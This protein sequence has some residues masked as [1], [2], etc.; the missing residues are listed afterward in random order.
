MVLDLYLFSVSLNGWS[1]CSARWSFNCWIRRFIY[2]AR[3][4]WSRGGAIDSSLCSENWAGLLLCRSSFTKSC[5][6]AVY[7][8][9]EGGIT[10]SVSGAEYSVLRISFVISVFFVFWNLSRS[11]RLF[12]LSSSK[13]S[14]R[15]FSRSRICFCLSGRLR[16]GSSATS[17]MFVWLSFYYAIAWGARSSCCCASTEFDEL[18]FGNFSWFWDKMW[19]FKIPPELAAV[20]DCLNWRV[21]FA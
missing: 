13:R 9:G 1:S 19:G 21:F 3:P 14:R 7:F 8:Y 2:W 5:F 6:G 4:S 10:F 11:F 15:L 17:V 18:K 12:W 20:A 16:E